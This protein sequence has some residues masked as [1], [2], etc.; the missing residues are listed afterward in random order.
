ME[1]LALAGGRRIRSMHQ[2][3]S[4][5]QRGVE[6]VPPARQIEIDQAQRDALIRRAQVTQ[7]RVGLVAGMV[8]A[9]KLHMPAAGELAFGAGAQEHQIAEGGQVLH[10]LHP[11][12]LHLLVP[13]RTRRR[14]ELDQIGAKARLGAGDP[15]LRG[16]GRFSLA[17][18]EA[19]PT[20][21]QHP[22]LR[23]LTKA[24]PLS[25]QLGQA[26]LRQFDEQPPVALVDDDDAGGQGPG[27][28]IVRGGEPA[29]PER[30]LR[31][32]QRPACGREQQRKRRQSH[33]FSGGMKFLPH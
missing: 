31:R 23:H 5:P 16:Q 14:M 26:G 32:A 9:V 29:A 2:P 6:G 28:E 10:G 15:P 8:L 12:E 4:P 19:L 30:L 25:L 1:D 20:G 27:H 7:G 17:N 24:E 18:V 11:I 3:G 21:G 13:R 22:R 33:G